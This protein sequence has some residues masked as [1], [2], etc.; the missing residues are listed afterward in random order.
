[1]ESRPIAY[2]FRTSQFFVDENNFPTTSVLFD[3]RR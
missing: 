1:M 2:H 3:T